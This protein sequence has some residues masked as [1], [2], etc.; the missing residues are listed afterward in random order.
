MLQRVET[1]IK[2][3]AVTQST[4]VETTMTKYFANFHASLQQLEKKLKENIA[5]VKKKNETTLLE[6]NIELLTNIRHLNS[7][8]SIAKTLNKS[9][10]NVKVNVQT[11]IQK[12]EMALQ[13]PCYLI[14]NKQRIDNIE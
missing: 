6:M 1:H 14:E 9:Q 7:L 5:E 3:K 4:K 2:N 12:L 8:I 11:I 10:T 13:L